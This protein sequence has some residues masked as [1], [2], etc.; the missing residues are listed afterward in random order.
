MRVPQGFRGT[1]KKT[2]LRKK[3]VETLYRPGLL[4]HVPINKGSLGEWTGLGARLQ[5]TTSASGSSIS[6]ERVKEP[7]GHLGGGEG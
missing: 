3:G 4:Q 1:D 5:K 2:W 7:T 6:D